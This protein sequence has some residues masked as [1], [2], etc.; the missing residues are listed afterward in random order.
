MTDVKEFYT[1][2]E[3]KNLLGVS[4]DEIVNAVTTQDIGIAY[5]TDYRWAVTDDNASYTL[6]FNKECVKCIE[7]VFRIDRGRNTEEYVCLISY[8]H[9]L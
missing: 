9:G 3:M 4:A 6:I 8:W 1:L 5:N 2:E 7:K